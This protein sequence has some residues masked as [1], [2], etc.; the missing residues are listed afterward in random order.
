MS[1]I[2]FKPVSNS[3]E[4]NVLLFS[5]FTFKIYLLQCVQNN[6]NSTQ[7]KKVIVDCIMIF[8][9]INSKFKLLF[10]F[11]FFIFPFCDLICCFVL[12]K[13]AVQQ[14]LMVLFFIFPQST[15]HIAFFLLDNIIFSDER[16]INKEK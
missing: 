13:I 16:H 14:F 8:L 4:N 5:L 7:K 1:S 15:L 2:I 9:E 10:F 12:Q 11:F 6:Y 3:L